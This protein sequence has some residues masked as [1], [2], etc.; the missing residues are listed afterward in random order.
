MLSSRIVEK[1]QPR[2]MWKFKI[3]EIYSNSPTVTDGV[4]Y[5]GSECIVALDSITGKMRWKV[6]KDRDFG[7]DCIDFEV[8]NSPVIADNT[9]FFSIMS[10][11]G[12]RIYALDSK[13]GQFK[14]RWIVPA[15][16][17]SCSLGS[18]Y[19]R[20]WNQNGDIV[21]IYHLFRNGW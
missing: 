3:G 5:F 1:R 18:D 13:T 2:L 15:K 21:I 11:L 14:N 16:L 20:G 10:A 8:F 4:V 6:E 17:D 19:F 9:A 7:S 12:E